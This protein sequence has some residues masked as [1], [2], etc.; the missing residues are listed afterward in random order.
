MSRYVFFRYGAKQPRGTAGYA[1]TPW[2]SMAMDLRL[3]PLGGILAYE[4]STQD[5]GI[6]YGLGFAHGTG[7]A[8]TLR[9]IDMHTEEGEKAHKEVIRIYNKG[10]V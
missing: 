2:I 7:G 4:S 5:T 3:I 6:L 10:H 8:I 1:L 9:R